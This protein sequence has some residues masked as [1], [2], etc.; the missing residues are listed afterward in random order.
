MFFRI[1]YLRFQA[2]VT[3]KI[4]LNNNTFQSYT[5]SCKTPN[6][7]HELTISMLDSFTNILFR[8]SIDNKNMTKLEKV[9]GYITLNDKQMYLTNFSTNL[10]GTFLVVLNY[11]CLFVFINRCT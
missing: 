6:N 10:T 11:V 8:F 7:I 1:E 2:K 3:A 9:Y 5:V 4:P